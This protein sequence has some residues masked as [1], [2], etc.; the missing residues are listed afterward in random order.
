MTSNDE[1]SP[2]EAAGY[3]FDL[4][5]TQIARRPADRRTDAR[6]LVLRRDG[7]RFTLTDST[8]AALPDWLSAGDTLI[9]NHT[10]VSARR[11]FLR[12]SS[13]G[14]LEALFLDRRTNGDWECLLRGRRK[15]RQAELLQAVTA[16]SA[17]IQNLGFQVNLL[18]NP[19]SGNV[20]L[21]PVNRNPGGIESNSDESEF[22]EKANDLLSA[23]PDLDAAERFFD[24]HGHI[25]LP[26][27]IDRPADGTDRVRYQTVFARKPGSVA[28][29]TAGLH[30]TE[31]LLD[32]MTQAG[33]QRLELELRVGYGTFAPLTE[34]NFQDNELH[35]ETYYI[36]PETAEHLNAMTDRHRRIAV[37]TTTLRALESNF[38]RHGRFQAG[39]ECTALFLRPP[40]RP[41]TIEGLIT[42][43]HLPRSSLMM[44]VATLTGRD[45]LLHAYQHAVQS[46]Y[47]FFSYG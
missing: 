8:F 47:R 25:P 6:L 18:D 11:V 42:N 15:L 28:A 23:W 16:Q 33:M 45:T 10:R 3:D 27:Y 26:P 20:L 32:R 29:P 43:F 41:C 14:R 21:R 17:D 44:L 7:T 40:E 2:R 22:A 39:T 30:F 4:P 34:R 31:T 1:N 9:F 24:A 12:R 13:G 38:R 19:G 46:G 37:G 5:D 36:P 35:R